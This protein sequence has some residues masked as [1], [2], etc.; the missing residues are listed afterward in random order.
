MVFN[1]DHFSLAQLD[2]TLHG[3]DSSERTF[4]FSSVSL[5]PLSFSLILSVSFPQ[6]LYFCQSSRAGCAA[7]RGSD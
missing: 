7:V 6:I 4:S 1:T 3:T 5:I 2:S